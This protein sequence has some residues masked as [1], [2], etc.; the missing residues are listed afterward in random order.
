MLDRGSFLS[1]LF[2][3]LGVL[4]IIFGIV[5]FDESLKPYDP[6]DSV[7]I[8]YKD[9]QEI[10]SAFKIGPNKAMSAAHVCEA[11]DVIDD[12]MIENDVTA[13][14]IDR[15]D[16]HFDTALDVC[17]LQTKVELEGHTFE[18]SDKSVFKYQLLKSYG[19]PGAVRP[20]LILDV[21]VLEKEVMH[22]PFYF[23]PNTLPTNYLIET[24]QQI[25]PGMSGGP[26]VNRKGK[27]VGV[28]ARVN[29]E[30]KRSYFAPAYRFK[31]WANEL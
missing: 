31:E 1:A 30:T 10:G 5:K 20:L 17:V 8:V 25:I 12:A 18:L 14:G 21:M 2:G 28:N 29:R 4:L 19:Y 24:T 6:K 22:A 3:T 11:L 9:M 16:I 27:V 7:Y 13:S 26:L 23:G 15:L